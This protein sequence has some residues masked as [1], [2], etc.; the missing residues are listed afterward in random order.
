MQAEPAEQVPSEVKFGLYERSEWAKRTLRK[1][2]KPRPVRTSEAGFASKRSKRSPRKPAKAKHTKQTKQRTE[3]HVRR[4][5]I[6]YSKNLLFIIVSEW[7]SPTKSRNL[8]RHA[9][10]IWAS[11]KWE[12]LILRGEGYQW[13]KKQITKMHLTW[14]DS[15]FNR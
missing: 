9:S 5:T 14:R 7:D 8:C 13:L 6:L 12:G 1:S 11:Q 10:Y 3:K 15:L 2:S 4:I